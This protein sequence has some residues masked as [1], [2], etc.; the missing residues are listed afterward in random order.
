M[1]RGKGAAPRGGPALESSRGTVERYGVQSEASEIGPDVGLNL[2]G[3]G[4]L[5]REVGASC[6]CFGV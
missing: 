5:I 3:L 1:H 4:F 6:R 2:L